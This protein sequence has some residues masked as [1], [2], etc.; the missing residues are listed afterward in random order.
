MNSAIS[1]DIFKSHR[2]ELWTPFLHAI[3]DYDLIKPNDSIAV[4]VSG[5][6]D[7]MLLAAL[8]EE[9]SRISSVPFS[10]KF[11]TMDPG[12][13]AE[14]RAIVESSAARIGIPL[15]M[16]DTDIFEVVQK[17]GPGHC[18]LCA[19]MRR[20]YL[21]KEAQLLGC[22]KIALAHHYDDVVETIFMGMTYG[23]QIQTMMPKLHSKNFNGMELIRPLY[24]VRERDIIAWRDRHGLA[25][26]NCGCPMNSCSLDYRNRNASKRGETKRLLAELAKKHPAIYD[27]IFRSV[28]RVNLST[29][30]GYIKDG[31]EHSFLEDYDS[32]LSDDVY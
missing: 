18:Y 6:K 5:G 32:A 27:C 28:H 14:N 25:C 9:L 19:R 20:G 12:Y 26:I 31:M 3:R 1:R 4:C 24:L 7:S 23:A 22:N 30:V 2:K 21:Y 13:S 15:N 16:F 11:L 8:M 29:V 17:A 10:V